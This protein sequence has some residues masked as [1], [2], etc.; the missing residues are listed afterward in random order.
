[1]SEKVKETQLRLMKLLLPYVQEGDTIFSDAELVY[2][3]GKRMYASWQA[4]Q[5]IIDPNE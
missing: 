2:Q 1:M 5:A 4:R 3:V